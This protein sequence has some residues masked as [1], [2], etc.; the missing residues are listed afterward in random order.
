M[1]EDFNQKFLLGHVY[2]EAVQLHFGRLRRFPDSSA[3]YQRLAVV[4]IV[5]AV[6]TKL[7]V[8][9]YKA[10]PSARKAEPCLGLATSVIHAASTPVDHSGL[11]TDCSSLCIISNM[12]TTSLSTGYLYDFMVV[13]FL[14][15][16]R[17]S[18]AWGTLYQC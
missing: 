11:L 10:T 13:T 7:S 4:Y 16:T 5:V 2:G 8:W 12:C 17:G 1:T 3:L 6:S 14:G 18:Q 15:F 9:I